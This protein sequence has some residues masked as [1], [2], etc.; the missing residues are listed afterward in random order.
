MQTSAFLPAVFHQTVV[1]LSFLW[2]QANVAK[3]LQQKTEKLEKLQQELQGL[4]D[5]DKHATEQN[6]KLRA[7]LMDKDLAL[8]E[9]QGDAERYKA[10]AT[11]AE[12]QV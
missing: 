7:T 12:K 4:K 11:E 2:W 5:S 3:N 8:M 10:N 9:A 6:D 1:A